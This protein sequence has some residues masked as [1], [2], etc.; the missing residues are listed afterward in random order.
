MSIKKNLK[1][2]LI[3]AFV[4]GIGVMFLI[5]VL[6]NV[7]EL[8]QTLKRVPIW[9]ILI[10]FTFYFTIYFIDSIR[11]GIVVSHFGNTIPFRHRLANGVLGIFYSNITPFAAGGQPYQIYQLSKVGVGSDIAAA[12]I[13]IRFIEYLLTS[14]LVSCGALVYLTVLKN[15]F[16][17]NNIINSMLYLGLGIS[18]I[19]SLF[20]LLIIVK[21]E[22]MLPI[23]LKILKKVKRLKWAE[24]LEQFTLE[25]HKAIYS[26]WD[27][28]KFILLIDTF[29]GLINLTLQGLSLWAALSFICG[30]LFN[31]IVVTMLF[32][33]MNLVVYFLPTPGASGGIEGLYTLV[34]TYL[35]NN[36]SGTTA[37]VIVWRFSTY[38]LHIVFQIIFNFLYT[39]KESL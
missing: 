11:L 37:A 10:C 38:Y 24:K 9:L 6:G 13:M 35:T 2:N 25:M 27:G 33:L 17:S 28:K 20:L 5:S 4:S 36:P 15:S 16:F 1:K 34:F 26:L 29:L 32:V 12:A 14:I 8:I 19:F 31:P 7:D 30:T 22:K 39:R 23:P 21:T 18:V 3:L